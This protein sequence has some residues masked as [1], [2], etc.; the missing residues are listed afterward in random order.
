MVAQW[1]EHRAEICCL[2]LVGDNYLASSSCDGSIILWCLRD[3]AVPNGAVTERDGMDV[4]G[5]PSARPAWFATGRVHTKLCGHTDYVLSTAFR[6]PYIVSGSLD[7]SVRVRAPQP[8]GQ[9]Q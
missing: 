2:T 5:A 4:D 1:H 8:D 6:H 3:F 7:E 9:R